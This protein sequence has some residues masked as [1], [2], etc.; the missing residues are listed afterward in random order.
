MMPLRV[1]LSILFAAILSQGVY[2]IEATPLEGTQRLTLP[3]HGDIPEQLRAGIKKFCAREIDKSVTE[4]AKLWHRDLSSAQA[5]EKSIAPNREHLRKMIGAVDARL[6]IPQLELVGGTSIPAKFAELQNFEVFAVRWPVLE[7][8]FGEGLLLRPKGSVKARVVAIPDADQTPEMISGIGGG[9][10]ADKQFA[11]KLAASGCE[12]IVPV[13]IDRHAIWSGDPDIS[14]INAPHREWVYRAG[15]EVGRHPIGY[16]VQKVLAAVE[17]MSHAGHGDGVAVG[18]AGYGEGGLIALYASALDPRIQSTLVSGYFDSRQNIADEPLYRNVFGLLHE[19]GD[20]EIASLNAPRALV[21]EHA[22]APKIDGPPAPKEGQKPY[23]A[24]GAIR[25]P[26]FESVRGEVDRAKT[27]FPGDSAVKPAIEL[28]SGD[29][30]PTTGPGSDA[31]LAA[32]M[33]GLGQKLLVA[34]TDVS[35]PSVID[36][37]ARQHRQLQELVDHTQ[38]IL[39]R[40]YKEREKFWK[41]ADASSVEKWTA[42]AKKYRDYFWDEIIG[43]FPK[44]TEPMNPRSRVVIDDPKF[45]AYEVTLDVWPDVFCYG[46]LLV[47]KEIKPGEKRPVVVCQHGLEGKPMDVITT[48]PKDPAYPIYHGFAK[49]LAERGFVTYAS[50]NFYRGGNEF[51]YVQRMLNPLKKSMFSIVL[52]QHERHLEWLATLPFVDAKR[53]GFYGLSY[54]GFSAIRL[55]PMLSGY[56]CSIS[57][58]EFSDMAQKAASVHSSY[59]YPFYSCQEVWEWNM[60]N[61]FG[62]SDLAGLMVPR[63]FMVERGHDDGVSPDEWVAAEYAKVRRR[64]DKLGLGDK[65]TIEFFNGVHEIHSTGTFEFLHKHLHWLA[66]TNP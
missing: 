3:M 45:T 22:E 42:S 12:V 1:L 17:W 58:G 16:E 27:L 19:F 46:I 65:T 44:A 30:G 50:H 56:A 53:I 6:P 55:P 39:Q 5:Y 2:A 29:N 49:R 9:L 52:A 18:V 43:R 4:R 35:L 13:L 8:V 25:T 10:S 60:A 66:P 37:A 41:D 20:A 15:F 59:S 61:T 23:G 33:K 32:F 26:K 40:S 11:R 38:V 36:T 7:G 31:A 34:R 24:P 21:I 64:Y 54:G 47:P 48:D 62:Y 57:S 28:I 51:R 63:P 14:M